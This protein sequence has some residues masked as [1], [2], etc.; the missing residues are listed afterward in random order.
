[1]AD[2]EE[3]STLPASPIATESEA[4]ETQ[5]QTQTVEETQTTQI[6]ET[7]HTPQSDLPRLIEYNRWA[8]VRS[9][10]IQTLLWVQFF[11]T[12]LYQAGSVTQTVSREVIRSFQSHLYV[13]FQGSPYPYRVQD[14]TLSGPG[15]PPIEWYYDADK[16]LFLSSSVYN[17]TTEYEAHHFEWLCGQIK[18][19]DLLLQDISEYLQQAKWAGTSRPSASVLV[20]AWSLHSGIVLHLSEGLRLHTINQD[21]SESAIPIRG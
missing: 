5:T 4:E 2:N 19:N 8:A 3:M 14:Y 17:T 15:V 18:Y 11:W 12:L 7:H 6:E 16:K 13:F 10:S 1:M 9:F 21:A 20:S